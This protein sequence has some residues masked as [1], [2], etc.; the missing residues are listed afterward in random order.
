MHY[1][2]IEAT[3]PWHGSHRT[4]KIV[5]KTA[6]THCD[7]SHAVRHSRVPGS[8]MFEHLLLGVLPPSDAMSKEHEL[9]VDLVRI[10]E[11]L[12]GGL[13]NPIQLDVDGHDD[14]VDN[15]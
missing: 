4:V 2:I 3:V 1:G 10:Y 13:H 6:R 7:I 11:S 15:D 5:T 9:V 8:D 14:N 12:S